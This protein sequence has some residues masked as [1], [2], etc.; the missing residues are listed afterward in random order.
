MSE[1]KV[2]RLVKIGMPHEEILKAS[3]DVDLIVIASH[4]C[5]SVMCEIEK[6]IGSTAENVV[7]HSKVPVLVIR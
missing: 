1:F 3:H 5:G 7:R 2:V 4:G 6:V